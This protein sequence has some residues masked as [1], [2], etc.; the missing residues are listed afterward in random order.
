MLERRRVRRALG[1]HQPRLGP[2][3]GRG[4]D[5]AGRRIH[6]ARGARREEHQAVLRP[7]DH[8]GLD[9]AHLVR[10]E[11]LAEPHDVRAEQRELAVR[12]TLTA[13]G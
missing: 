2:E 4:V 6:R 12:L 9:P 11:R 7:L 13:G 3:L 8:E 10:V 5:E 1:V